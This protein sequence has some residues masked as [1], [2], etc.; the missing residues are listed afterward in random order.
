M[1]ATS[2]FAKLAPGAICPDWADSAWFHL[3]NIACKGS[4]KPRNQQEKKVESFYEVAIGEIL[5]PAAKN[6]NYAV[7]FGFGGAFSFSGQEQGSFQRPERS[8]FNII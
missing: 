4:E 6:K 3:V 5:F 7:A 2:S 8:A 1:E